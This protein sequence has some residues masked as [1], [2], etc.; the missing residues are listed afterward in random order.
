MKF[1]FVIPPVNHLEL[2][3]TKYDAVY[4]LA[5]L[6]LEEKNEDYQDYIDFFKE[7]AR[8]GYHVILDNGAAE[9]SLV[10]TDVLVDLV[11]E[12]NPTEVIAPDVLYDAD[13]TIE[14]LKSFKDALG[15][16]DVDIFGCPQ[17]D[18]I[19]AYLRCYHHMLNDDNV[20]TIGLSKLTIPHI[21]KDIVGFKDVAKNRLSLVQLLDGIDFLTKPIHLLGMR[22]PHEFKH[23]TDEEYPMI[24]ST[25]S[26][27]TILS[28]TRDQLFEDI[29]EDDLVEDG[30]PE[31]YFYQSLSPEEIAKAKKN[32][33][34]MQVTIDA[35]RS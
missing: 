33:K 26:C 13:A 17:G 29:A 28:A 23:Y 9:K 24:R 21:M 32:I 18:N 7:K 1:N 3:D 22:N 30:T 31:E 15:D 6:C 2:A 12:I 25:D 19:L 14:N 4:A 20:S 16:R 5:H 8:Q 10:T 35:G 27:F 11:D 34:W